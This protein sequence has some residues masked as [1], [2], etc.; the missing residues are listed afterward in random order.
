VVR[1]VPVRWLIAT[2]VAA[3]PCATGAGE[4]AR[5]HSQHWND[6]TPAFWMAANVEACRAGLKLGGKAAAACRKNTR[7]MI[8]NGT[9]VLVTANDGDVAT[10]TMME[11]RHAGDWGVIGSEEIDSTGQSEGEQASKPRPDLKRQ[12]ASRT[13]AP[14]SKKRG[15]R[16]RVAETIRARCLDSCLTATSV[17]GVDACQASCR[18]DYERTIR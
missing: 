13:A 12:A 11:G 4:V 5:I 2:L 6:G 18:E 8:E 17:T 9:H 7:F 10:I 3:I 14:E 15:A 1:T 16:I